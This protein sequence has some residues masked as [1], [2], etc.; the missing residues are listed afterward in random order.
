MGSRMAPTICCARS[1]TLP[2]GNWEPWPIN[3][4]MTT[5]LKY[6]SEC[7]IF[8]LTD[9]EPALGSRWSK[10]GNISSFLDTGCSEQL[11]IRCANWKSTGPMLVERPPSQDDA[12]L[13][14]APPSHLMF[15]WRQRYLP[16]RNGLYRAVL[17]PVSPCISFFFFPLFKPIFLSG[18]SHMCCAMCAL[19]RRQERL[20]EKEMDL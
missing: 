1:K 11:Q 10:G 13:A 6:Q 18:A 3:P 17:V 2:L 14:S 5:I 8:W 12:F 15:G 19:S 20:G 16:W 9:S 7:S 4:L